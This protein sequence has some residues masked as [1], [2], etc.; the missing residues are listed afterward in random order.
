MQIYLARPGGPRQGP[1]TVEQINADLAARK[2]RDDDFWA[3]HYGLPKWVPLYSVGGISGA[4]DTTFFFCGLA[5]ANS[6]A[7]TKPPEPPGSDT[8]V[9]LA[10]PPWL[11]VLQQSA[12]V[13]ALHFPAEPE[14][15]TVVLLEPTP[16]SRK[17]QPLREAQAEV[18]EASA[19]PTPAAEEPAQGLNEAI[20]AS[21]DQFTP[22]DSP[23]PDSEAPAVEAPVLLDPQT[24]PKESQPLCEAQT[25]EVAVCVG[26]TPAVEEFP[27][28]LSA[29]SSVVV[30]LATSVELPMP[31]DTESPEPVVVRAGRAKSSKRRTV[32]RR[33]LFLLEG[34]ATRQGGSSARPAKV[35][36]RPFASRKRRKPLTGKA[37]ELQPAWN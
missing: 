17:S 10:K 26:P 13:N 22:A 5:T 31:T 29:A 30:K 11:D 1:Y 9:F 33:R 15:D 19:A 2:Y 3:W 36:R 35:P 6:K 34:Q 7:R 25:A 8:A 21:G 37:P 28:E 12:E 18:I 27:I 24:A 32:G 14:V 20:E 4:A 16:A 23:V